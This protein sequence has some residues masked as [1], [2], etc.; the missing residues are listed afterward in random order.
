MIRKLCLISE[1][2][3]EGRDPCGQPR[4]WH[5]GLSEDRRRVL[6][7]GGGGGASVQLLLLPER[8]FRGLRDSEDYEFDFALTCFTGSFQ[9]ERGMVFLMIEESMI[10]QR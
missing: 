7:G 1:C 8:S 5:R 6:L 3:K 2:I 4:L 9:S 10:G